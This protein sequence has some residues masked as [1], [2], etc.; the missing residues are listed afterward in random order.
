MLDRLLVLVVLPVMAHRRDRD[1]AVARLQGERARVP[2]R[3]EAGRREQPRDDK[4][5]DCRQPRKPFQTL[6]FTGRIHTRR[7]AP[8]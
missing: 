4:Q 1:R 8:R 6:D 5:Q 2:V 3:H 7:L